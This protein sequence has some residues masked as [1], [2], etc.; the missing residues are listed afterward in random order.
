MKPKKIIERITGRL[1][2]DWGTGKYVCSDVDPPNYR[3]DEGK[4]YKI[5]KYDIDNLAQSLSDMGVKDGQAFTI[6]LKGFDIEER[7]HLWDGKFR[8]T[9]KNED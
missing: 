3:F 2:F 8:V 4:R 7:M 1:W 9:N 5:M 6:E